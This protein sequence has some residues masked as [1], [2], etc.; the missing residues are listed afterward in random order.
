MGNHERFAAILTWMSGQSDDLNSRRA[1]PNSGAGG[2]SFPR[3]LE[4]PMRFRGFGPA[5]MPLGVVALA[6]S[7]VDERES[8]PWPA[9][10]ITPA[11]EFITSLYFAHSADSCRAESEIGGRKA[12]LLGNVFLTE[13]Y[14]AAWIG[15]YTR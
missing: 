13:V 10:G 12:A 3:S 8:D 11:E 4:F 9:V 2:R 14:R 1:L 7:S 5:G 15:G 6:G